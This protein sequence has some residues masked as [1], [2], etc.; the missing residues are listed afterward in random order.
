M[1]RAFPDLPMVGTGYSWLQKYA[2]NAGARNVAEGGV[3]FM[4]TGRGALA[5]PD[6]EL[7]TTQAVTEMSEMAAK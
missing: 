6:F 2:I 1:Q 5:Y 7:K 3:A 4:G